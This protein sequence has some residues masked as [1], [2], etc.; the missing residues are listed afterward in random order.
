[1][2]TSTTEIYTYGHTLTLHDALPI[3]SL[4][5][6]NARSRRVAFSSSDS[7]RTLAPLLLISSMP[8]SR[9]FLY[10]ACS[11]GTASAKVCLIVAWCSSGRLDHQPG[12]NKIGRAS[13]RERVCQ[14][15]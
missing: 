8:S 12:L 3:S 13:C 11:S 5:G 14:Y 9:C 6:S 7:T 10:S 15:V 1:M 4:V 2:D